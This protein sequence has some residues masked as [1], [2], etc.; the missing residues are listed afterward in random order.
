MKKAGFSLISMLLFSGLAPAATT[1][2]VVPPGTPG[3]ATAPGFTSWGT[4]ATNIQHAVDAAET[5]DLILVTNGTY[6]LTSEISIAK[7]I[8]LRSFKNET[9]DRDGTILDGN[10]PATSNRCLYVYA[11]GAVVDGFTITNGAPLATSRSGHGGGLYLRSGVV[12]NC[13]IIGN[14]AAA[15]GGGAYIQ[16]DCTLANC[17]VSGNTALDPAA[18]SVRTGGGLYSYLGGVVTNCVIAENRA[19]DGGGVASSNGGNSGGLLLV[20][21]TIIS[22]TAAP[23]T[24]Q[25]GAGGQGGGVFGANRHVLDRCIIAYNQAL[26]SAG[27]SGSSSYGAGVNLGE[28]G[29]LKDSDIAY[30]TGATYGGGATVGRNRIAERC[31]FRHNGAVYGAGVYL[32]NASALAT[33]CT[34][35]SNTAGASAV[36]VQGGTL[37]NSL[38]A[39]N[40]GGVNGFSTSGGVYQNCT[41]AN[42]T[43]GLS[44][45]TGMTG[46]V[47]NCI[48]YLNSG[49]AQYAGAAVWTNSCTY[50]MPSGSYNAGVETNAP[51]FMN[52]ALGDFSLHGS[53]T[54]ID[55][56][57]YRAWM[58]GAKDLAGN[59]RI[60]GAAVDMG[61]FEAPLSPG[62]VILVR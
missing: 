33:D 16:T 42:N 31:E 58:A 59:F 48:V 53:S 49:T 20:D 6:R 51:R 7:K 1:R 26:P 44:F 24:G 47:E 2:Y 56:G 41:I 22:N 46:L 32:S 11:V 12:R 37:R 57:V 38:V 18:N 50:P 23:A 60:I 4:A 14:R 5:D 8:T 40:K 52:A 34:I 17:I 61:A 15:S 30:N 43:A 39:F 13:R 28:W 54:C 45:N 10:F 36:F 21:C 29:I 9:T 62:F 27:G 55:K 25:T 35:V 19:R 3:V